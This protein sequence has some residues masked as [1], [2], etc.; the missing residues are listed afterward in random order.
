VFKQQHDE[1]L[2]R[3]RDF[4]AEVSKL[5]GPLSRDQMAELKKRY[6]ELAAERELLQALADLQPN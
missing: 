5:V 3:I 4:D 2:N 6:E 1:L